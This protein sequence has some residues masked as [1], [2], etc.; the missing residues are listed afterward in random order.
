MRPRSRSPSFTK[1]AWLL[2]LRSKLRRR[3]K[4]DRRQAWDKIV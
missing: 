4:G 3:R 2:R 1:F